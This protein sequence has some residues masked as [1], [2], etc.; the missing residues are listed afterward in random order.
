MTSVCLLIMS[1][2]SSVSIATGYGLD[3]QMNGVR[4][5]VGLG[6]FLFDTMFRPA[7]GPTQPPVRWV[8][9]VLSLEVKRPEREADHSAPS[10]A[11]VKNAWSYTSIPQYAFMA[12][13]LVKH[14]DNFTLPVSPFPSVLFS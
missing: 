4:F 5:P 10:S 7:L 11:E 8:P 2:D 6:V 13:C 14:G 1:R 12:W 9:G 3:D